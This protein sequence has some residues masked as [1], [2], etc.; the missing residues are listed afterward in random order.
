MSERIALSD[1]D[2]IFI[3][4][5]ANGLIITVFYNHEGVSSTI[6]FVAKSLNEA[7]NVL[8]INIFDTFTNTV[9]VE[10]ND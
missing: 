5:A 3:K 8:K 9:E 10:N 6:D 7:T 4:P 1:I 2:E